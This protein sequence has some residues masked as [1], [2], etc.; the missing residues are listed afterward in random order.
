MPRVKVNYEDVAQAEHSNFHAMDLR[1]PRCT[2]CGIVFTG[3]DEAVR[4]G[5]KTH[6]TRKYIKMY[7]P[8][9]LGLI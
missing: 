6:S 8:Q 1:R 3:L 9:Q 5:L 7:V 2:L 4:H